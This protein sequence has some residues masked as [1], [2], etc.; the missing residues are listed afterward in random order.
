MIVL[1]NMSFTMSQ[2]LLMNVCRSI[3]HFSIDK[4]HLMS[5]HG[6]QLT[7]KIIISET[8]ARNKQKNYSACT[9]IKE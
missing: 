9:L 8:I 4:I 5:R 1:K 6:E 3:G 7:R 2:Q